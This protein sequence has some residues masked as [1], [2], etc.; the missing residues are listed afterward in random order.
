MTKIKS[1]IDLTEKINKISESMCKFNELLIKTTKELEFNLNKI[2]QS[3][4]IHSDFI[5]FIET[6]NLYENY[7]WTNLK[8]NYNF[9]KKKIN[10]DKKII[11]RI[12]KFLGSLTNYYTQFEIE[13][14]NLKI[15]DI[16]C[17][18]EFMM[19]RFNQL[20]RL[21]DEVHNKRKYMIRNDAIIKI[22]DINDTNKHLLLKIYE[23]YISIK[24]LNIKFM[25]LRNVRKHLIHEINYIQANSLTLKES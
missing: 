18:I 16:G 20:Q 8:S 3:H 17:K 2:E 4:E 13:N 19:Y 1:K 14:I 15:N 10:K 9:I 25:N 6:M 5:N 7:R 22:D 24:M 23:N 11:N 21:H 12:T